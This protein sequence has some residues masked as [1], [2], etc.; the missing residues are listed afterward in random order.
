MKSKLLSGVACLTG[1]VALSDQGVA[2]D[3]MPLKARPLPIPV[4][5]WAGFYVGGHAVY[6]DTDYSSV[7][8]S[9][10]AKKN[11]AHKLNLSG[12]GVGIHA[13]YNFQMGHW[14]FGAESDVT[15]LNW[16]NSKDIILPGS[17]NK[18]HHVNA[19]LSSLSSIRGRLGMTYDR[20]LIYLTGG[21]AFARSN[22]ENIQ[23][24]KTAVTFG[25]RKTDTGA[26]VGGG[27]EWKYSSNL[28]LRLEGLEYFF[29]DND[30]VVEVVKSD[31][32]GTTTLTHKLNDIGVVRFGASWRY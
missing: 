15:V 29:K 23:T 16:D 26:V 27:I 12:L 14:V 2:A 10:S 1:L 21:V 8:L 25:G 17:G 7:F 31:A 6:G 9:P 5:T 20:A 19:N 4:D 32:K 13:G 3:M 22:Y 30:G 11:Y 18:R 24:S 28:S